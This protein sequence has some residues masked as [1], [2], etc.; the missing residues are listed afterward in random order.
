MKKFNEYLTFPEELPLVPLKGS[1]LF[2]G[3]ASTVRI[4]GLHDKEDVFTGKGDQAM[5][6]AISLKKNFDLIELEQDDFFTTGTLALIES[7]EYK[8]EEL[9]L[10]LRG[11]ERIK[12]HHV[13]KID[14]ILYAKIEIMETIDDL[15][16]ENSRVL[17]EQL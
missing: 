15:D 3:G 4:S 14:R 9:Q 1:I 7:T 6:A 17:A 12:L 11:L 2:P 10:N 8:N 16:D 13:R 5:V